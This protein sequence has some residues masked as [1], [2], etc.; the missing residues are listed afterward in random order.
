VGG[1]LQ[2]DRLCEK[3]CNQIIGRIFPSGISTTVFIIIF[4]YDIHPHVS[5][6]SKFDRIKLIMN[7]MSY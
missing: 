1:G 3:G 2:P 7:R 5:T 4:Y 6:V